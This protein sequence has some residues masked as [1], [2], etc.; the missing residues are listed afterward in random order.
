MLIY[1][2]IK[3][4]IMIY[5]MMCIICPQVFYSSSGMWIL[6]TSVHW[7]LTAVHFH[8]GFTA[9]D[10]S[11]EVEGQVSAVSSELSV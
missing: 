7:G 8:S 6:C 11:C 10:C 9:Y 3:A 5:V 1:V 4:H 2:S